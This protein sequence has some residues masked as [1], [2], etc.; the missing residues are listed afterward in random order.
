MSFHFKLFVYSTGE[1]ALFINSLIFFKVSALYGKNKILAWSENY[2]YH[3][4]GK[5]Y[6]LTPH[7]LTGDG[8]P[9]ASVHSLKKGLHCAKAEQAFFYVIYVYLLNI[10]YFCT[11]NDELKL[12]LNN[13][14]LPLAE[15]F[16]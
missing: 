12:Y 11:S 13:V 5:L 7:S 9:T 3:E 14:F 2:R 6:H 15:Y 1:Y 10:I 4:I 8:V 16:L